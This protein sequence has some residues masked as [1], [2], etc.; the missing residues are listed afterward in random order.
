M[1]HVGSFVIRGNARFP[2]FVVPFVIRVDTLDPV[3]CRLHGP[4]GEAFVALECEI[5]VKSKKAK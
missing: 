2:A 5:R 4:A 3:V 1:L